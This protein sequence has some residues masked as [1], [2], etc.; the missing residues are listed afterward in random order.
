MPFARPTLGALVQQT[1]AAMLA[2]RADLRTALQAAV[3]RVLARVF[4]GCLHQ[5]YGFL[6]WIARQVMPG[7][8]D[9]EYLARWC[10]MFGIARVGAVAA[11]G[12][13]TIFGTNGAI[14]A[15]GSSFTR[16]DGAR[17]ATTAGAT[18][19]SG[20]ATVAVLA[21]TPG[22]AG[23]TDAGTTLSLVVAATG[24]QGTATVASG[25]LTGGTDQQSL[26]D[27]QAALEARLQTPP[28][29]GAPADYVAWA[30]LVPGV[31]RAWVYPRNRGVGTVD[32]CFVMDGRSNIIPLSADVAAV[33]AVID[34]RRPVTADCVV[35]APTGVPRT[36]TVTGLLP[37]TLAVKTAAQAEWNAQ[38]LRDGV[39]AGATLLGTGGTIIGTSAGT[40]RYSRLDDAI[41]RATDEESHTLTTPA[42]DI[43]P[44]AGQIY[45]PGT[46]TFV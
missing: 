30:K 19:A 4:A 37:N 44:S 18:I 14:L 26:A 28:Q 1:W 17:F 41:S 2:Q 40:L 27:W 46:L 12:N 16:A 45:T 10:R 8:Q 6:D 34:A 31:T 3:V 9:E 20:T 32:L 39:P 23:N 29:G 11:A 43:S 5:L 35:F 38:I 24:I 36:G 7:A 33:Q 21:T 15:S 42:A 25:G 13:L 22:S